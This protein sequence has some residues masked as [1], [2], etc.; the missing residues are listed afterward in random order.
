MYDIIGDIH[1]YAAPLKELLL[2]MDYKEVDGAYTHTNRKAI[3]IGDYIDRGPAIRETLQLVKAMTER[4]AAIALLGN[5]EFNA[6]AYAYQLPDGSYL[7]KHNDKHTNQHIATLEQF[8]D[9][10]GEWK[11]Y[12]DWFYSLPLFLELPGLRAVH[13]CWD[14]KHIDWLEERD[15]RTLREDLLI[16]SH[17]KG[18]YP[19]LVIEEVL[20]GKEYNIPEG[21]EWEDKDGHIRK[22]NRYR[23]WINPMGNCFGDFL[24]DCPPSLQ[25]IPIEEEVKTAVYPN[26]AP[27]VFIGHYWLDNDR[28]SIQAHNVACLDYSVAK[29]GS[30]VAY[31]WNGESKLH[32]DNFV[33]VSSKQ[34]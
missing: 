14:Q 3:F 26:E 12:L 9:Y 22:A 1:G 23:W 4:G 20:K 29:Q 30:L 24:F 19:H 10:P 2:K 15:Y 25:M 6:M 8:K 18:S 27:P 31:R 16:D 5:H 17:Q 21:M 28:P 13:A 34:R 33:S 32:N 11:S 7:R